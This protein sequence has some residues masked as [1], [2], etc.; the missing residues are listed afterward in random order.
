MKFEEVMPA[1]KNGK[2]IKRKEWFEDNGYRTAEKALAKI[3]CLNALVLKE[4]KGFVVPEKRFE[5]SEHHSSLKHLYERKGF[6]LSAFK[7]PNK[8]QVLRN[9]VETEIGLYVLNNLKG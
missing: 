3:R 6:D 7:I 9:C 4:V 5:A 8:R 1:L 2:K